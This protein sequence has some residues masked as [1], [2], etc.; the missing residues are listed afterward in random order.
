MR[1]VGGVNEI[2]EVELGSQI[3]W[4]WVKDGNQGE[5]EEVVTGGK[6]VFSLHTDDIIRMGW[7]ESCQ[8]QFPFTAKREEFH[9]K[10]PSATSVF[11]FFFL[12]H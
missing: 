1:T 12:S 8:F 5:V 7:A 3:R 10:V 6:L 9:P 2:E 4:G 11:F